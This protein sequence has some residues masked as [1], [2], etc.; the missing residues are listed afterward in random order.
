MLDS[1]K[2]ALAADIQ[3]KLEG[4]NGSTPV[5]DAFTQAAKL[6]DFGDAMHF[7]ET[8]HGAGGDSEVSVMPSAPAATAGPKTLE[9]A[10]AAAAM[11]WFDANGPGATTVSPDAPAGG[12]LGKQ[13]AAAWGNKA[14]YDNLAEEIGDD[15][16][17]ASMKAG[18]GKAGL[19]PDQVSE[20]AADPSYNKINT[21]LYEEFSQ[22]I[23]DGKSTTPS[24][25][26]NEQ[27]HAAAAEVQQAAQQLM[28]KNGWAP[29]NTSVQYLQT[30]LMKA[31]LQE[32][33]EKLDL[34]GAASPPTMA[35]VAATAPSV[36]TTVGTGTSVD[37]VS[38]EKQQEI[39]G[40]LKSLASGK[41]LS[42]PKEITYGNLLALAA[43]HGTD[44]QPLSVMQV[45]KSVD[46]AFSK[47]LGV[48][49]SN[50]WENEFV[51][52]LKTP[53]GAAFAKA[54]PTADANLVKKF[55]GVYDGP[56]TDLAKLAK[57]VKLLPGPGPFDDS[58]KSTDFQVIDQAKGNELRK[59]ML[60]SSGGS[61]SA[62]E[63]SGLKT[64]TGSSYMSMNAYLRGEDA[65]TSQPYKTAVKNTQAAMRPLPE[66]VL[67]HRGTGWEQL[68]EG[69][70]SP[71]GA[72]KLL[73]KTVMDEAFMSTSVGGSAAF[74]GPLLLEIEAPKGTHAAFVEGADAQGNLISTH[75]GEREMLLAAGQSFK[76]IGVST[77]GHQ[78]VLRMRIVTAK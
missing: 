47:Q 21:A 32:L 34:G 19:N 51:D 67:L 45:L 6:G 55:K 24:G 65:D 7:I 63:L 17:A 71:A 2:A 60:A 70:R 54:N 48:A 10:Q 23:K 13:I 64:Y 42:D 74:G 12:D 38:F 16:A 29:D 31:K 35:S 78:T 28:D 59:Q 52:W 75:Q 30:E 41:Y 43:A 61:Y 18:W 73:G 8:A 44:D 68:P 1:S 77:K 5:L 14:K 66:N 4:G 49:N 3:K 36:S 46:N 57:K 15:M 22:A 9:Q 20:I 58:V 39:L 11:L 62:A 56:T 25:G 27:L 76:I 50:K 53:E 33:A 26:A 40:D 37:G 72:K 69:F